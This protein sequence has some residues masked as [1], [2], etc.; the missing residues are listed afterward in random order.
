MLLELCRVPVMGRHACHP[1]EQR[2]SF[3]VLVS[4]IKNAFVSGGEKRFVGAARLPHV[5]VSGL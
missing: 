3:I 1:I 2:K 4:S 5:M